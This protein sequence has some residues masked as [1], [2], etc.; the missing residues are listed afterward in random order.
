MQKY[1]SDFDADKFE[2]EVEFDPMV[3]LRRQKNID[4]GKGTAEY[5]RYIKMVPL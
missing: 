5:Q 2:A 1:G 4:Y 3:L